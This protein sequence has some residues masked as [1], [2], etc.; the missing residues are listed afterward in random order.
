MAKKHVLVDACV[1][2]LLLT[3]ADRNAAR[4]ACALG[5]SDSLISLEKLLREC[6]TSN[7]AIRK[8]EPHE[9]EN[10]LAG[11]KLSVSLGLVR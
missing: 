2:F 4:T 3:T 1:I 11:V 9:T 6:G 10:F 8:L 5:W 7:T